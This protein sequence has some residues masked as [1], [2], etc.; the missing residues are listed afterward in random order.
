MGTTTVNCDQMTQIPS[1]PLYTHA[2]IRCLI[3]VIIIINIEYI[4]DD[5]NNG[6]NNNRT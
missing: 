5:S 3:N 4:S 1:D 2:K 6:S